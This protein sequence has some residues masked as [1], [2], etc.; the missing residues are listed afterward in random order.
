MLEA[1]AEFFFEVFI[2]VIFY[3]SFRFIGACVKWLFFLGKKSFKT[4]LK[5]SWNGRLGLLTIIFIVGI[6]ITISNY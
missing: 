3:K 2:E 4:I 5:E 6:L 1:I